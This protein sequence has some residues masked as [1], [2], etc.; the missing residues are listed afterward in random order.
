VKEG[1]VIQVEKLE[2]E[3]GKTY[4][5]EKVLLL[6]KDDKS[7]EVGTPFLTNKVE[8]KVLEQGKADK[9]RVFKMK[10]KKNYKRT[11]GHRQPFTEVEITKIG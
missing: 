4:T 2:A 9:I 5:F 6:S 7:V 3:V 10:A 11:Y 8:G 1:D